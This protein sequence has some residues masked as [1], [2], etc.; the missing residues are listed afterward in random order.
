MNDIY[1]KKIIDQYTS[2]SKLFMTLII[3]AVNSKIEDSS[4]VPIINGNT[5]QS[6]DVHSSSNSI[7]PNI[8]FDSYIN[9]MSI[10][11]SPKNLSQ[12]ESEHSLYKT[13]KYTNSGRK[14]TPASLRRSASTVSDIQFMRRGKSTVNNLKFIFTYNKI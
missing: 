8:T 12:I 10:E 3:G 6:F 4:P 11:L 9:T 1:K 14:K 7:Q 13:G 2:S 5:H